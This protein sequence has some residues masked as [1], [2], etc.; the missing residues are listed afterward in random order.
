[1]AEKPK[2]SASSGRTI[3]QLCTAKLVPVPRSIPAMPKRMPDL[4]YIRTDIQ[5][6]HVSRH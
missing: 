2:R 6:V 1:M 5:V 4:T 3:R